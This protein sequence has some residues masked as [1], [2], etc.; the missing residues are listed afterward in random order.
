MSTT[1][2][3]KL[4]D[5]PDQKISVS[6]HQPKKK[7]KQA[8]IIAPG[9]GGNKDSKF[10]TSLC[11]SVANAGLLAI[12]F[13]YIYMEN[14]KKAP[15]KLDKCASVYKDVINF[16]IKDLKVKQNSIILGGKSMGSRVAAELSKGTENSKVIAFGY[17]LHPPGK[18]E[19]SRADQIKHLNERI[20][21]IQGE[22]DAFGKKDEILND[23]PKKSKKVFIPF[24]N[25]SLEVPK[26]SGLTA[27]EVQKLV[28]DGILDFIK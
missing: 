6:I 12:R 22:N 5:Y 26:K 16:L 7:Y 20:L 27:E 18:P 25:H 3:I 23:T 2:K 21:I 4:T 28:I 8:L 24:G 1:K 10:L 14:G 17:P 19:K 15:D 11:D 9:A 13:N